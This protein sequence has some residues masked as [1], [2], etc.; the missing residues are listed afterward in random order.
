MKRHLFVALTMASMLHA[1]APASAATDVDTAAKD[2]DHA[3]AQATTDVAHGT[4]EAAKKTTQTT[5]HAV[6]KTGHSIEKGGG[7][8]A[9]QGEISKLLHAIRR[10]G[11]QVGRQFD[12]SASYS[13][14]AAVRNTCVPGAGKDCR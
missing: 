14:G 5:G 13:R 2:T 8:T 3:P 10:A 11:A 7:R 1:G 6:D 4:A 12:P 9:D